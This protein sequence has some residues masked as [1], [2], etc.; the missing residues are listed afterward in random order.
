V[1]GDGRGVAARPDGH[2]D[3][4]VAR[5]V[6]DL[7]WFGAEEGRRVVDAGRIIGVD[8]VED[9]VNAPRR[10]L[11]PIRFGRARFKNR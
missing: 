10:A 8:G 1:L 7:N 6:L 2:R 3:R 9:G 4:L 5:P 11:S